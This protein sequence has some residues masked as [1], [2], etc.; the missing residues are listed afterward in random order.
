[1]N[2]TIFSNRMKAMLIALTGLFAFTSLSAQWTVTPSTITGPNAYYSWTGN[3]GIGNNTPTNKLDVIG[4]TS[5]QGNTSI[6]GTTTIDGSILFNGTTGSTPTSGAGTRL[7]WIPVKYSFR[8]GYAVSTNWD[9]TNIGN[10]SSGFG[11]GTK[12]SGIKSFVFGNNTTGSGINSTAWGDSTKATDTNSTSFG[13]YCQSKAK[14]SVAWGE[15][16]VAS[17]KNSTAWGKNT[18]ASGIN[19]TAIGYSVTANGQNSLACGTNVSSGGYSGSFIAGDG[20]ST[21]ISNDTINQFKS[22]YSGGYKIYSNSA[23]TIGVQLKAGTSGWV[24]ISDRNMKENFKTLDLE[25]VLESISRIPVSEWSYKTADPNIRY[26]GPMAQ[27]FDK[28]FH[29]SGKDGKG[30]NSIDIDGVNM[31]GIQALEKRTNALKLENE[32]L[33]KTVEDLKNEILAIK[34]M[35][36]RSNSNIQN[37]SLPENTKKASLIGNNPNPFNETTLISYYLPENSGKAELIISEAIGSIPLIRL[38]LIGT[39]LGKIEVN[40][41]EIKTGTYI[42]SLVIN[43]NVVDTK[44]M[45]V[46]K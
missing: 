17:G 8:A 15:S 44:K 31:A 46:S 42:Y 22:R 23:G 16:T 28:E 41:G 24:V 3:V 21:L 20:T 1:M 39:G 34:E 11:Y 33:K 7:M 5:L 18:I 2:K 19:S 6:I 10:Y 14:N 12:A 38:N 40:K 4:T 37:I 32:N 27:D 43:G 25:K 9:A 35:L 26:I 29:I 30:I 13:Y 45:V 36:G